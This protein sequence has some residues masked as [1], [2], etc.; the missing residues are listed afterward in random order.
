MTHDVRHQS[1]LSGAKKALPL[2]RSCSQPAGVTFTPLHFLPPLFPRP[3]LAVLAI[4]QNLAANKRT[5]YSLN[6]VTYTKPSVPFLL[7]DFK[8]LSNVY[9]PVLLPTRPSASLLS[10]TGGPC[11]A[12]PTSM[13]IPY[14]SM[15]QMVFQNHV[16]PG[17]LHVWHVHGFSFYHVARWVCGA[18]V[19]NIVAMKLSCGGHTM[20]CLPSFY[21]WCW[22]RLLLVHTCLMRWLETG[23][24]IKS[25]EVRWPV[26]RCSTALYRRSLPCCFLAALWFTGNR[27]SFC[28]LYFP[29]CPPALSS[30]VSLS[31]GS[32]TGTFNASNWRNYSYNLI[33]PPFRNTVSVSCLQLTFS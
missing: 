27:V 5:V 30:S 16:P 31:I 20:K 9:S 10:S 18:H 32:G 29:S 13:P 3:S 6:N 1:F 33:N 23:G 25:A 15:V 4:N 11:V 2:L 7:A 8:K 22:D 28:C 26:I 12:K 19:R 24:S 14:G 17:G 21:V